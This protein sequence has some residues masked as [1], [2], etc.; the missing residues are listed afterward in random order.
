MIF[1]IKSLLLQKSLSTIIAPHGMTDLMHAEQY[2]LT[3]QLVRINAMSMLTSHFLHNM[4]GGNILTGA[5]LVSSVVHFRHDMPVVKNVPRFVLSG[6]LIPTFVV[7]PLLFYAY[8]LF[9][10]VPNH[11]KM[12]WQFIKPKLVKN[13]L[14]LLGVTLAFSLGGDMLFDT[15]LNSYLVDLS[16]GVV[17]AH[18]VYEET[19]IHEHVGGG[20]E[21]DVDASM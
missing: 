5:F 6:V 4:D 18:I 14:V 15:F 13:L 8:M 1:P 11:Y 17:I 3:A 2:G 20:L 12:N 19:F 9:I 10:H 7:N 16:K 21:E